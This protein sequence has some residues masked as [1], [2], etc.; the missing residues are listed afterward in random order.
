VIILSTHIVSDISNLC[1]RMAIIRRGRI[2]ASCTPQQAIDQLQESVW[3]ATVP[4]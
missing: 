1:S 3:E 4:R 2:L